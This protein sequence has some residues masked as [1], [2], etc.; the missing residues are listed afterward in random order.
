[1]LFIAGWDGWVMEDSMI[2]TRGW[3]IRSWRTTSKTQLVT[4][5]TGLF[6]ADLVGVDSMTNGSM[7]LYHCTVIS[8]IYIVS[9]ICL[10]V[11]QFFQVFGYIYTT[12]MY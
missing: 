3:Y 2:K 10:I 11:F 7:I 12:M 6:L 1:M 5:N 4:S 9:Y 8:D